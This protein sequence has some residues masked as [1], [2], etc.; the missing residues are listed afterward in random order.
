MFDDDNHA[1]SSDEN[2][3]VSNIISKLQES[4]VEK[5]QKK[6]RNSTPKKKKQDEPIAVMPCKI[7][8]TRLQ[9]ANVPPEIVLPDIDWERVLSSEGNKK[10]FT[11]LLCTRA[12]H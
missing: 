3:I 10:I 9:S 5:K 11:Q 8:C 4:P 1:E 12:N 2:N 6:D 7:P